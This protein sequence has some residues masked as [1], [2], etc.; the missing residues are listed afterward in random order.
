MLF[1]VPIG[2]G[3]KSR[4]FCFVRSFIADKDTLS[5]A[6]LEENEEDVN[7]GPQL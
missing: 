5:P 2:D 6:P 1:C 4:G 7:N 3:G